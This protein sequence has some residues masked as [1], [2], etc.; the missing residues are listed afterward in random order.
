M[1]KNKKEK[2]EEVIKMTGKVTKMHSTK[3]YDVLLEND[4][5]IKA[6]ISGKMS[7]HNIKLIPGDLVDVEISP[8]N[9]TLGRIVFRHK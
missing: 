2:K 1:G 9:L 6:Y 7:L 8:F 3:N 5:E 4:Q